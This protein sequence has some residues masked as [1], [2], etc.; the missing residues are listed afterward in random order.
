MKFTANKTE[1]DKNKHGELFKKIDPEYGIE[2]LIEQ[3]RNENW[4]VYDVLLD[5]VLVGIFICRVDKLIND[6]VELVILH[7]ASKLTEPIAFF[8]VIE[9]LFDIIAKNSNC[10]TIRLHTVTDAVARLVVKHTDNFTV[11]ETVFRKV[12]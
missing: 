10:K 9:P 12:L 5:S 8:A 11:S 4:T 6:D 7:V 1:Y 2:K 3:V